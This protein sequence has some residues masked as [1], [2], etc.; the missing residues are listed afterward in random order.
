MTPFNILIFPCGSE[1]AL[2]IHRSLRYSAHVR[3][4]GANSVPDHGRFVFE[5]Y[6][7][8]L[9]FVTEKDFLPQLKSIIESLKIDAIYPAMDSV[10][11]ILKEN[12][13]YLG[14]KV[15]S[16]PIET[17]K[18]CLSKEKTYNVLNGLIPIPRVFSNP[19]QV[20]QYPVF[21]KPRIGYGS[22]G[23]KKI[24]DR[25]KMNIQ[26]EEYPDSL[27]MEYLP[28]KE[29]TIDCFSDKDGKLLF[30]GAR[31]RQRIS[32]GISVNTT[33]VKDKRFGE[34]ARKINDALQFQGAWFFQVKENADNELVLMEVASR[35]GGSSALYRNKGVNFALL[36]IFD[37]F[38]YNLNITENDYDIELDR[39]LDNRYKI[40]IEYDEAYIDFDD[41][42]IIENKVNRQLIAFVYQCIANGKKVIL[43]TKHSKNIAD[44]LKKFRVDGLFDKIIH[45]AQSDKK[46]QHITTR[47]A[48]F[49][50]DSFAERNEVHANLGIPV[51]SPDMVESLLEN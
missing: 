2:E 4:F 26:F 47:S 10:V 18:I 28:G 17:T 38:G 39:A 20:S 41:C 33:T 48:I 30:S 27:V 49:I 37:A 51:F 6:I 21:M 9:P 24:N 22:R 32:N 16:S 13:A 12:E 46:F 43:L 44:S 31:V 36:S 50:D 25:E 11:T 23:A 1:V 8:D 5:Q 3:L 40:G 29:Y 7:G 19:E 15:I 42:L 34:Y 35:M 14:C 45:I